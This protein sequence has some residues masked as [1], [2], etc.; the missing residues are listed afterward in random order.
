MMKKAD[1]VHMIH[2]PGAGP[3]VAERKQHQWGRRQEG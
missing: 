1:Q 2:S 3:V